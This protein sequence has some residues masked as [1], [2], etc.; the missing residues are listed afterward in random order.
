M[1]NFISN[2]ALSIH[3]GRKMQEV[4]RCV[5]IHI[6]RT[7]WEKEPGPGFIGRPGGDPLV[8]E[9]DSYILFKW[10]WSWKRIHQADPWDGQPR[11]VWFHHHYDSRWKDRSDRKNRKNKN[12]GLTGQPE[13]LISKNAYQRKVV[14]FVSWIKKA[15]KERLKWQI[16][17]KTCKSHTHAL[18]KIKTTWAGSTFRWAPAA[19]FPVSFATEGSMMRRKGRE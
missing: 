11:K 3:T 1:R 15:E 4:R 9:G 18:G 14:F 12:K 2:T 16:H 19:I 13:V 8:R 17:I 5:K 6:K 10:F 7:T